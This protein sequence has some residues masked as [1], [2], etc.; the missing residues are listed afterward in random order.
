MSPKPL[1]LI[2]AA[3]A[4][5]M[6]IPMLGAPAQAATKAE[7][8]RAQN[9]NVYVQGDSLTVGAGPY[10]RQKLGNDVHNVDVDAQVGRFTATGM[11]RLAGSASAKRAKVWVV[12]LGTNDGPDPSA[13][14]RHVVRSLQ[15][16]GQNREVIWL[17]V[18]RPGGYGRVNAM[19][20]QLDQQAD[21]LHVV[22]W[23]RH[24]HVHRGLIGSDGVHATAYGYQ[25]RADMIAQTAR[26]LARQP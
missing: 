21:R 6:A 22:D 25:V 20:R 5:L 11:S 9:T 2:A 3:L 13:L 24:V 19:L 12:A 26:E 4:A 1:A 16:A 18:Q 8:A 15:L 7:K 10:L 17:T 23:A 14:K